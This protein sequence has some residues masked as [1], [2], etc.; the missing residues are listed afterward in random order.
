MAEQT[1]KKITTGQFAFDLTVDPN[2]RMASHVTELGYKV[3]IQDAINQWEREIGYPTIDGKKQKR[4][5]GFTRKS[6]PFTKAN[7]DLLKAKI[8]K[9]QV[10]LSENDTPDL[11]DNG[12]M[13]VSEPELY[14]GTVVVPKYKNAKDNI[15]S[16][17]FEADGKTPKK[18]QDGTERTIESLCELK[19]FTVPT[20]PWEQDTEFLQEVSEYLKNVF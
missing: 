16:Y 9:I 17:L 3:L 6:I 19:S 8:D 12:I 10:D 5:T 7:A 1:I 15:N 20:D 4:P 11:V 13:D 2:E 18:K 14:E